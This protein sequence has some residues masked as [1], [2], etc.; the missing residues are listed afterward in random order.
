MMKFCRKMFF[1]RELYNSPGTLVGPAWDLPDSFYG[2]LV[3]IYRFLVLIIFDI[4][5]AKMKKYGR[6]FFTRGVHSSP[7]ALMEPSRDL[8]DDFYEIIVIE[9]EF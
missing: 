3:V 7:S 2:I 5:R 1:T 8:P 9:I 4:F 6:F